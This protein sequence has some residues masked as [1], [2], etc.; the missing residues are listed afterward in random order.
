MSRI[1][2]VEDDP[3]TSAILSRALDRSGHE[4]EIAKNGLAAVEML[5]GGGFGV[6][7]TDIRMPRLGGEEL[8]RMVRADERY[9][10]LPIFVTTGVVDPEKLFWVDAY[11]GVE[12]HSKPIQVSSLIE[13]I[14][15]LTTG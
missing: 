13:R 8:C 3:V 6:L 9:Q 5:E 14:D 2:L 10:D 4:V 1:L 11:H 7:I 12:V 15:Q